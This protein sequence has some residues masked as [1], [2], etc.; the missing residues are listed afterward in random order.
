MGMLLPG[1]AGF[2][3]HVTL[4]VL[5]LVMTL[6]TMGV[7]GNIFRSPRTLVVPALLGILMNY[8]L[9][10]GFL[11]GMS[12]LFI[13]EESLRKG[14]IIL[15]SVPPAVAVI[16]FTEFLEGDR[17]YSLIGTVGAY[18]GALI[19][20]PLLAYFMLGADFFD[21]VKLLVI[22][23]ELI[24]IPMFLSRIFLWK[25]MDKWLNPVKGTI[26]NWSFFVVTYTIV[27]LNQDVFV[28]QTLT[29]LPIMGIAIGSTFILGFL[30]ERVGRVIRT[31][32]KVLNSMVL[33]GT[34]K[35]YGL[36]GGIALGL[37]G[38]QTALP[39]TVSTV[40]MI[41]YIIWLS[42]KKGSDRP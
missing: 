36:G 40:F 28:H 15:A 23:V 19:I 11:L 14:F 2:T 30:V 33:L 6:S 1:A 35:N 10:G 9:L 20:M 27:G 38:K 32:P 37:F 39:A 17:T 34:L 21:P 4:P 5:A 31:R 7:Q 24:L 22:M 12:A 29:L 16:P 18:L 13:Q 8:V 26:T 25:G 3:Y 41:V 42:V